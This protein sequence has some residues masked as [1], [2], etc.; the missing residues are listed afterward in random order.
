[1]AKLSIFL[2]GF[3]VAFTAAQS[4]TPSGAPAAPPKPEECATKIYSTIK[5]FKGSKD[6][7]F[8]RLEE[9]FN[10]NMKNMKVTTLNQDNWNTIVDLVS[11]RITKDDP[12]T[13][14]EF[15]KN[16]DNLINK[17][18]ANNKN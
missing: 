11:K 3:L 6:D 5:G 7:L 16:A 14:D 1:M 4:T 17:W 18:R 2:V 13:V 15:K 8:K 12:I 9:E 10:V